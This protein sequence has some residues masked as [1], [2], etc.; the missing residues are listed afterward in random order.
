MTEPTQAHTPNPQN[1]PELP[2]LTIGQKIKYSLIALVIVG[3]IGGLIA[4]S[5][6]SSN[7]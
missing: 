5:I 2:P 1:Q 6:T 3:A 4:W 7:T